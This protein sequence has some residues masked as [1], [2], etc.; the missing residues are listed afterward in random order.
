[1]P[2]PRDRTGEVHGRLTVLRKSERRLYYWCRCEC[3]TEKEIA[4]TSLAMGTS[5]S[6]G[7]LRR[8]MVAAK[9]RTHGMSKTPT[10]STWLA[11]KARCLDPNSIGYAHYGGRGITICDRWSASYEAFLA[12]MGE[13]PTGMTLDRIDNSRHY[14]PGNC[15]WATQSEQMRNTRVNRL[16]TFRGVT[17]SMAEWADAVGLSYPVLQSRLDQRGWSVERALTTPLLRQGR[18]TGT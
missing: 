11:V 7:C 16:L 10:Y 15:R 4:Q 9:N 5:K 6:C 14:E 2:P 18:K 3:G 12:D 17:Q 13:R 8:E 1:M